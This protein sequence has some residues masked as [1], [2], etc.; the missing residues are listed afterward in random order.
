VRTNSVP[1]VRSVWNL[2]GYESVW[3]VEK[4]VVFYVEI[5]MV[6]VSIVRMWIVKEIDGSYVLSID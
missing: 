2:F 3:S 5:G 4:E 1:F 6:A